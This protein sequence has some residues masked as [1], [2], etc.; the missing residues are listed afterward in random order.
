MITFKQFFDKWNG[1]GI[2]FDGVYGKQCVDLFRMYVKECTIF[3][4]AKAVV[5]ARE[6]WLNYDTDPA[7]KNNYEKIPNS[8][9][10]YPQEGDVVIWNS[11][12]GPYGHIAVCITGDTKS[13]TC[14]SQ[15]DPA[16]TLPS[17]KTY[18]SW[19]GVNGWLRPHK[20]YVE[21]PAVEI[22]LETD[23]KWQEV[24][25]F[26]MIDT[27]APASQAIDKYKEA[28]QDRKNK[29]DIIDALN[30]KIEGLQIQYQA[31][32][33]QL[34]VEYQ[35]RYDTAKSEWRID[36][37]RTIE[38]YEK[39]LKE[40]PTIVK[41]VETPLVVRFK[42]KKLSDKIAGILEILSAR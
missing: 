4:Q 31:E 37:Q 8:P 29:S 19:K 23:Y 15:N 28:E 3:P 42:D 33:S 1:K 5:G 26:L 11:S 32:L 20:A 24:A 18:T 14:F 9:T 7:L 38:D 6:F 30:K 12:Y 25:K 13:F 21:P 22:P 10:V 34:G 39:K 27:T 36:L 16:G 41:E 35:A 40:I 17:S 2:D